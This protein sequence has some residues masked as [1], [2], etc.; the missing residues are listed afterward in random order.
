MFK[1]LTL[2]QGALPL[3]LGLS[4]LLVCNAGQVDKMAKSYFHPPYGGGSGAYQ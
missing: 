1:N 2:D 3:T 4:I